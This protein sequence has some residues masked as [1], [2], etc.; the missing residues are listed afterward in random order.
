MASTL[1]RNSAASGQVAATDELGNDAKVAATDAQ[2]AE[3]RCDILCTFS[4]TTVDADGSISSRLSPLLPLYQPSSF[5]IFFLFFR[6]VSRYF[7][8]PK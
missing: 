4:C 1:P 3:E 5:F 6:H 2:R 7:R 8:H